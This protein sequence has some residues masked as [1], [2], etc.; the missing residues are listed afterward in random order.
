METYVFIGWTGVPPNVE[1]ARG[2]VERII[3]DSNRASEVIDDI[4]NLVKKTPPHREEVDLNDLIYRTLT[5]ANG[6]TTREQVEL[7]TELAAACQTFWLIEYSC[8]RC[9]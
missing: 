5:L 9:S 7:Q 4:R 1:K 8:N 6:E 3:R 2:A